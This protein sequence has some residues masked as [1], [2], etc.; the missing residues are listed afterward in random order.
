MA[1]SQLSSG[2]KNI[3]SDEPLKDD[4]CQISARSENRQP[5]CA[6]ERGSVPRRNDYSIGRPRG[7]GPR[8]K[9]WS[10]AAISALLSVNAPAV[11]LSAACSGVEAFGIANTEVSRVRK[12]SAT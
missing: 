2:A 11:A 10:S 7:F 5:I 12:P 8:G 9:A 6:I 3:E 4:N 1:G